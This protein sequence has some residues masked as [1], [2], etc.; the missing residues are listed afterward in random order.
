LAL[1]IECAL[2]GTSPHVQPLDN[3]AGSP[4]SEYLTVSVVTK[5]KA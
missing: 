2:R 1:F 5:E 3:S 4:A